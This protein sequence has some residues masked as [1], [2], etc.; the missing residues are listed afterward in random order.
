MANVGRRDVEPL[1]S[2][3]VEQLFDVVFRDRRRPSPTRLVL[4][5]LTQERTLVSQRFSQRPSFDEATQSWV[6]TSDA[7]VA[8]RLA[9][10]QLWL[11]SGLPLESVERRAL[12]QALAASTG[13]GLDAFK[14]AAER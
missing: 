1:S 5:S 14:A 2:R 10:D 3:E 6:A 11:A 7:G 8:I 9:A 12:Q 13:F 4:Q